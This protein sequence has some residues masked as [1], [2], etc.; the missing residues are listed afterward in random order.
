MPTPISINANFIDLTGNAIQGYMQAA[1]VSLTQSA[2]LLVDGVG[3]LSPKIV[4]SSVGSSVTVSLWGND[5][6]DDS[7][8]AAFDTYY[9]VSLFDTSGILKCKAPY[10]FTGTGSVNLV[11]YP[12]LTDFP[13]NIGT[14]PMNLLTG[15]NL[16]TGTNTFSIPLSVRS[17][18]TWNTLTK[19]TTYSVNAGEL[20]LAD[21]T[22][23]GFTITLPLSSANA[24]LAIRIK[25]ISSDG[26]TVTV[27]VSGSDHI[28]GATTKTFTSQYTSIDV[29]ADGSGNWWIT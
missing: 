22:G 9:T 2:N 14:A 19:T 24:N 10:I 21:T 3:V 26:N 5:V 27:G 4:T 13:P 16:W 29:I 28:D 20:I 17:L 23:G 7:S 6:V 8:A 12:I 25:K 11:G 1:V 18:A 15:N